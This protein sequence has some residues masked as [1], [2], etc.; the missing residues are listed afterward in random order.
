M[1]T[2][3]VETPSSENLSNG[4]TA[5]PQARGPSPSYARAQPELWAGSVPID[6]QRRGKRSRRTQPERTACF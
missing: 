4:C 2:V 1:L 6:R 5:V 3:S